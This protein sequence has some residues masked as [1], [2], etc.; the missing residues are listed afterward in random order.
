MAGHATRMAR[1]AENMKKLVL[2]MIC[3]IDVLRQSHPQLSPVVEE[4]RY[5]ARFSRHL[6]DAAHCSFYTVHT[7]RNN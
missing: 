6:K 4:E 1:E 3:G 2:E 5:G 7:G